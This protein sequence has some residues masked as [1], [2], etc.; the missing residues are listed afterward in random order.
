[1]QLDEFATAALE[2][3]RG[4]GL[5]RQLRA[6]AG[7]QGSRIV[8]DGR[9]VVNFSSN[10]YLGLANDPLL[11]EAA[12]HAIERY[13]VGSGASRLVCGNIAPYAELEARLAAFKGKEAAVVF[14]SG[15]A[16]VGTICTLVGKGDTVILDKLDH[17]SIVDG[18]RQSGA[19]IRVYPHGDLNKLEKLLQAK[20]DGCVLIVTET[21]FSMDG[22]IAPL[23][24]IVELK[25]RYGAWLMIDEAH[26]TGLY[27]QRRRG[28]AEALGVEDR[29]DVT[30][31]T[32]SKALGCVGGFVC[33]SQA[34][35]DLL[36]NRA[37]S[38]IYSTALP[39]AMVAA[40]SA[41]VKFVMSRGGEAR[42]NEL[43]WRVNELRK[44]LG[45]ESGA[46][47][48]PNQ[49][50]SPI[51][52]LLIGDEARAVECS[53]QLFERGLFAPAIRYPTVARGAAR[54]RLTVTAAHTSEQTKLLIK[55]LS[56]SDC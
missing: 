40:A 4:A 45:K 12:T 35:V 11:Q 49:L 44:G 21:V 23:R 22:D 51:I 38:L 17:A 19:T 16:N 39:P 25:D 1:M 33:G 26:A 30:L 54:L 55:A 46:S 5:F 8:V 41:A 14:G 27:G 13:G 15:Y 20:R 37:R 24:E 2:D 36:V 47:V 50:G 43:W 9:E 18:A 29:V 42:C 52:P 56:E 6:V 7:P 28:V 3:L 32:L 34:L 53:R 31:G 10:D 48:S